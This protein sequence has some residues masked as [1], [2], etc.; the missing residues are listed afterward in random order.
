MS[1]RRF[2]CCAH[3]DALC[4][5]RDCVDG[6]RYVEEQPWMNAGMDWPTVEQLLDHAEG[7]GA[8]MRDWNEHEEHLRIRRIYATTKQNLDRYGAYSP[9]FQV[10]LRE[11]GDAVTLMKFGVE[12]ID[13]TLDDEREES[14]DPPPAY[15]QLGLL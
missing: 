12:Q 1:V 2:S 3:L 15:E 6:W 9:H 8:R 10:R 11:V 14:A 4:G 13:L 5:H 7:F